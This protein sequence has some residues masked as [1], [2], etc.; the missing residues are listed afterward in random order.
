VVERA[1]RAP[2]GTFYAPGVWGPDVE[3][4]EAAAHH[5]TVKRLSVGDPVRLSDGDGRRATGAISHLGKRRLS[6]AVDPA[7]V[8]AAPALPHV[9]LWAPVGDRE[10][11][12]LL[13]EKAVELGVSVWRPVVYRRSR[14]VTPRGEGEAFREKV[15]LRMVSAL[16]QSGSAWFPRLCPEATLDA[17]LRDATD[18]EGLLLDAAGEPFQAL[19][20]SLRAPLALG[21]GPEGGLEAEEREAFLG[22]GWRTVSLGSNVL[23]FETAGIAALALVRSLIP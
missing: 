7:T 1:D 12:L 8:D 6:I 17:A 16:E 2:V 5:A 11:M 22:A 23:R 9:E 20:G 13:A 18:V 15:R 21:L 14:S 3:L 4:E 19:R 10:R